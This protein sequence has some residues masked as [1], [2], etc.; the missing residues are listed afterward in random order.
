MKVF[1]DEF[2]KRAGEKLRDWGFN[3]FLCALGLAFIVLC[4]VVFFLVAVLG[5][6][7]RSLE[8]M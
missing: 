8:L 5:E 3:L 6:G 1:T 4:M 2:S 7:F